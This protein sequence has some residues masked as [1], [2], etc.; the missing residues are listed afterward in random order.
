MFF[1][2]NLYSKVKMDNNDK[3]LVL[4]LS[5]LSNRKKW[6]DI[7]SDMIYRKNVIQ[8]IEK[9]VIIGLIRM[10]YNIQNI[11]YYV[12]RMRPLILKCEILLYTD[13]ETKNIKDYSNISKLESR[14]KEKVT[15]LS[16]IICNK[17]QI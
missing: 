7:Y 2:F 13:S 15:L 1:I 17:K 11:N 16:N 6:H 4:L 14:I 10:G 3:Y 8:I 5:S 9:M 12:F